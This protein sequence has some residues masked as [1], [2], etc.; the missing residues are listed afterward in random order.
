MASTFTTTDAAASRST[1]EKIDS[2]LDEL[3]RLARNESNSDAFY[4]QLLET[5]TVAIGAVAA[6]IWMPVPG[7]KLAPLRQYGL[8]QALG[9]PR[10]RAVA[11]ESDRYRSVLTTDRAATFAADSAIGVSCGVLACPLKNSAGT[12]GVLAIYIPGETPAVA[13]EK[14]L[15]FAHAV[16]G[17]ALEHELHRQVAQVEDTVRLAQRVEAFSLRVH[18]PCD[19][20]DTA[21]ELANEGRRLVG[22]D[23]LIVL[24]RDGAGWRVAAVSGVDEVAK[25]AGEMRR[26]QE[27]V[28]RVVQSGQSFIYRGESSELAPEVEAELLRYLDG[29]AARELVI[30]PG[31]PPSHDEASNSQPYE[32]TIVAE[33]FAGRLPV[34]WIA[35]IETVAE[36]A[37]VALP[38]ARALHRLRFL[39]GSLAGRIGHAWPFSFRSAAALAIVSVVAMTAIALTFVPTDF[40]VVAHGRLQPQVREWVFAPADGV[41]DELVVD[42]GQSVTQGAKLL[43]LRSS[44]LDLEIQ[45]VEG[46]L[47]TARQELVLITTAK[48]Q[49][50]AENSSTDVEASNLISKQLHAEERIHNFESQLRILMAKK[51]A[52]VVTSPFNGTVLTWQPAHFLRARPVERGTALLEIG[53]LAG[54]WVVELDVPDG[55]AGHV[56]KALEA[57]PGDVAASFVAATNPTRRYGGKIAR[58]AQSTHLDE[59]GES[60][61]RMVVDLDENEISDHRH[62]AAVIAKIHCGRRSLGFVWFHELIEEL[63]RRFF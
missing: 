62:G 30:A 36:H 17:I 29:A 52:L 35:R 60:A 42:H 57:R 61:V 49:H 56:L 44:E 15:S 21:Y 25:R 8:D 2:L 23:R 41:V 54:E 53:D 27:L 7:R 46:Q 10:H 16:A 47:E 9:Q 18:Q 5:A 59:N 45:Q 22:C 24:V 48:L 13:R 31:V 20:A 39:F 6:A 63:E 3:S 14:L 40:R 12:K 58:V 28:G 38:R 26:L 11:A 50:A 1:V 55:R 37:A 4:S 34:E 43:T 19:P 32:V 33:Q 51:A